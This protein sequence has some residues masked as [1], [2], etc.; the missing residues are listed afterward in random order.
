METYIVTLTNSNI[1]KIGRSINSK[2]RYKELETA[3]P[4]LNSIYIFK[5]DVEKQLHN[6]FKSCKVKNEWF[7]IATNE[8]YT[9]Y[10]IVL[11]IEKYLKQNINFEKEM[12]EVTHFL[13]TAYYMQNLPEQ[14]KTRNNTKNYINYYYI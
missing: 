1:V 8:F 10:E 7:E 11:F 9:I 12:N 4:F 6:Y 14:N 3:N 5:F 13:K 2:K